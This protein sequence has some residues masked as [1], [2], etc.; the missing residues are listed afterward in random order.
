[1]SSSVTG[2]TE[3][4]EPVLA[5]VMAGSGGTD[6]LLERIA[7]AAVQVV[8]PADVASV[9]LVDSSGQPHTPA[10]SSPVGL[11]LD[12]LQYS[13]GEGPCLEVATT[14]AP[15]KGSGDLSSSTQWPT[16]GPAAAAEGYLAVLA[17][18]LS[19]TLQ[20]VGRSAPPFGALNLYSREPEAF[21]AD[22]QN[23]AVM[24]AA[25]AGAAVTA[26]SA[27]SH[28]EDL[29]TALHSRDVIGQA[30]GILMERHSLDSDQAFAVLRRVSNDL[31][32]R[33]RDLAHLVARGED[34]PPAGA[35][36]VRPGTGQPLP[37]VRPGDTSAESSLAET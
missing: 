23:L 18:G 7:V 21:S 37:A 2:L 35:T 27:M 13:T 11:R 10:A 30:K 12:A 32:V 8:G 16:F 4:F 20:P 26:S 36:T 22:D 19:H 6:Q 31:N 3:A 15:A 24:L 34:L 14:L 1:M 29:Q 33:I 9:T 17:V 5:S 25:F 28:A